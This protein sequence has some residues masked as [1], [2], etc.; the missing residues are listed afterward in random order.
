MITIAAV[1]MVLGLILGLRSHWSDL[2]VTTL[3]ATLPVLATFGPT[4]TALI[5]LALSWLLLQ[6]GYV[7]ALVLRA[8][9]SVGDLGTDPAAGAPVP[10]RVTAARPR[11]R[12]DF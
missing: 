1:S 5:A 6:T 4:S 8:S 9:G 7:L 11:R 3:F 10:V 2:L 12:A